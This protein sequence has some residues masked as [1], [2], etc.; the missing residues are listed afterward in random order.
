MGTPKKKK[1]QTDWL[2]HGKNTPGKHTNQRK[3][4]F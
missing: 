3:E 2:K 1:S 4:W